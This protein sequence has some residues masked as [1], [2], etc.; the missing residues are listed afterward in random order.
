M[1]P[2]PEGEGMGQ[3]R[4]LTLQD[5]AFTRGIPIL[6]CGDGG[7]LII[8]RNADQGTTKQKH[9]DEQKLVGMTHLIG[10]DIDNKKENKERRWEAESSHG[11]ALDKQKPI[12]HWHKILGYTLVGK[13]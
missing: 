3:N 1:L 13:Q 9:R 4:S 10:I 7:I 12:L 11:D 6:Q 8:R 2:G 5:S